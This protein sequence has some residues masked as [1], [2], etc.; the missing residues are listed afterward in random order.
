MLLTMLNG[1]FRSFIDVFP[2][3]KER[4][5]KLAEHLDITVV[6]LAQQAT[7]GLKGLISN[8]GD[9]RGV[10]R[11]IHDSL[12][13]F[14]CLLKGLHPGSNARN[15]HGC[16]DF[17]ACQVGNDLAWSPLVSLA[18]NAALCYFSRSSNEFLKCI[19]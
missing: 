9:N 13:G 5:V 1:C 4:V 11:I 15:T 10:D 12:S 18:G 6:C 2:W 7:H 14:V 8:H 19:G 3:V 17:P 16:H